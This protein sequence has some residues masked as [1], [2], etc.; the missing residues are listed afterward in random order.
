MTKK[1]NKGFDWQGY[2]KNNWQPLAIGILIGFVLRELLIVV[3]LAAMAFAVAALIN[4]KNAEKV[5]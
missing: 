4:K 3:I 5:K 1:T 2:L